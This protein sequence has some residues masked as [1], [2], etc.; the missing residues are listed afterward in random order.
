MSFQFHK[1]RRLPPYLFAEVNAMKAAARAEG[2]DIIDFGM[3]NPDSA[4]PKHIVDKLTEAVADPRTHRYSTSKGI[5]GLR[6]AIAGYYDRRF[7]VQ[8]NADSE[9]VVTLGSKEGLANLA[10]AITSPGDIVLALSLIHI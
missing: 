2:R 9:V 3:G 6:R 1:I 4:T 7:D 10:Q 5:P 8:L